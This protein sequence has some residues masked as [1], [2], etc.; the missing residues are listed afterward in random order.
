MTAT[1]FIGGIE[2]QRKLLVAVFAAM[3]GT[4]S[5]GA[6]VADEDEFKAR[7]TAEAEN[8]GITDPDEY[9]DFVEQCIADYSDGQSDIRPPTE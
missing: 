5:S 8:H 9:A 7:C 3:I 1:D 2:M 6:L 4:A